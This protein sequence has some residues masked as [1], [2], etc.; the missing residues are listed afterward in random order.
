MRARHVWITC[1]LFPAT[2]AQAPPAPSAAEQTALVADIRQNVLDYVNHLPDFICT[3]VTRRS[4]ARIVRNAEPDW[5]PQDTLTIRLTYFGRRE[6]Y[7]VVSVNDQPADR[8]FEKM[9]GF[10]AMGDFGSMLVDIFA[11]RSQARFTWTRW[12]SAVDRRAAV[13]GYRIER[14]NSSFRAN[15]GR[16][17]GSSH[18]SFGAEGEVWVDAEKHQVLRVTIHSIDVPANCPAKDVGISLDYGYQ[19]VGEREFLLPAR[20]VSRMALSREQFQTDTTFS[21]YK[22]FSADAGITF[23]DPI[24]QK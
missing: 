18:Y 3:Q 11:P 2:A 14:A 22:K 8:R 1:I 23:G 17:I 9:Q 24:E 21:D 10:K 12:D 7:R 6:N 15:F 20:S 5:K 4:N 16:L 19:K 13:L